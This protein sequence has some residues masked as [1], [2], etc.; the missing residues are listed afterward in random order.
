MA[1]I[2]TN[3]GHYI[4]LEVSH[5]RACRERLEPES[6]RGAV[7]NR[8]LDD[9]QELTK[10]FL[11]M[12]LSGLCMDPIFVKE[13]HFADPSDT[14]PSLPRAA[15]RSSDPFDPARAKSSQGQKRDLKDDTM[16]HTELPVPDAA[17]NNSRSTKR[18]PD[19]VNLH[20]STEAA[21]EKRRLELLKPRQVV[22]AW[23]LHRAVTEGARYGA[24]GKAEATLA[25]NLDPREWTAIGERLAL[26]AVSI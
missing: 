23:E 6:S 16:G 24:A 25:W 14:V 9:T 21:R 13:R 5:S 1:S 2:E 4:M 12:R 8:K 22:F 7:L 19:T 3:C 11:P 10:C 17:M 15:T 26:S 18:P 20:E